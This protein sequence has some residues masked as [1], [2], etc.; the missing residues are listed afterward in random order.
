VTPDQGFKVK[1]VLKGEYLEN[2]AF[3]TH[4]YYRMLIGNIGKLSNGVTFD[5]LE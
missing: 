2:D 5:A 1:V 4:I 3:Y